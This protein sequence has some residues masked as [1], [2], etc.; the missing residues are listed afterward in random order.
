[1]RFI[2]IRQLGAQARATL[3]RF[4][5]VLL[6]A[7]VAATAALVAVDKSGSNVQ[8]LRILLTALLGLPLF[9]AAITTAERANWTRPTRLASQAIAL[10]VLV[11]FWWTSAQWTESLRATRF[12][13]LAIAFHLM[14]AFL[15]FTGTPLSRAFW[16]YNRVLFLRYLT[17]S[18]FSAVLFAGLA[19]ALAAIDKLFGVKVEPNWYLRLWIVLAFIFHPWYFLGGVPRDLAALEARDDYPA[20]LKVFAQFILIPVV[21]VYLAILTAYLVRVLAT[22]TWP[23]GWIG[24][25]VSSVSAAGTLALLLVHPVRQRA[26]SRWVDAYGRWFY[27]ALLPSIGMLL[28]AIWLRVHQYG[29][30]ENR[31]FLTVL[32]VWLLGVALYY[33]ITGSRNIRVIPSSLAALALVTFLGPWAAYPVAQSSQV[34]RLRDLLTRAGV[35]RDSV[36]LRSTRDVSFEERRAMSGVVRYLIDTH[37]ARS[38]AA[39]SGALRQAAETV[40]PRPSPVQPT[41]HPAAESVM[42][43]LGVAYVTRWESG[44]TEE[45]AFYSDVASEPIPIE[46]YQW[47]QRGNLVSTFTIPLG[48]D[49]LSFSKAGPPAQSVVTLRGQSLLEIPLWPLL[50]QARESQRSGNAPLAPAQG[51]RVRNRTPL[52]L[53]AEGGGLRMRIIVTGLSG[54]GNG[55]T[56]E[57]TSV[58]ATILLTWAR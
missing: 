55:P 40:P 53:T 33:G 49:T 36:I 46:G 24:Y 2:S 34:R 29:F 54:H 47:M 20:G 48:G 56:A 35:L 17:A 37:G 19:I 38:L 52:T 12:V 11:A 42:A 10:L 26:D 6:S 41:D 9:T 57:V 30:T 3:A 15:P 45:V 21:T 5:L 13:H 27:V 28:M 43:R 25:L 39:V 50:D 8:L 44:P 4:P 22:R 58:D 32:A 16:Q 14:V 23:S 18:L 31:Y 7:A 1:M 51:R